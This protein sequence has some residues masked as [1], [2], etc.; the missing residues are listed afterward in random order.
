MSVM[1]QLQLFYVFSVLS[2]LV[3]IAWLII[4]YDLLR[5]WMHL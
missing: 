3:V 4:L 5:V 2:P 1:Q